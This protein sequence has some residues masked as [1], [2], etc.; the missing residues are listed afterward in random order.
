MSTEDCCSKPSLSIPSEHR[1]T[2][3]FVHLCDSVCCILFQAN[4]DTHFQRASLHAIR[5]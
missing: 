2:T 1:P 4:V 3:S 5:P